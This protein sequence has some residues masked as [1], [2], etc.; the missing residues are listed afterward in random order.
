MRRK[1]HFPLKERR[2]F[3]KKAVILGA[4]AVCAAAGGR[5]PAAAVKTGPAPVP[6]PCG[7]YRLTAHIRKY[8][9]RAAL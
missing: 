7:G 1:N 3:F 6:G 8:Y 9:E 5:R 2:D 4:A